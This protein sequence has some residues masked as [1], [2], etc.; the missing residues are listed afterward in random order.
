MTV[1]AEHSTV[2]EVVRHDANR[3]TIYRR[4]ADTRVAFLTNVYILG[5]ADYSRLLAA[6]P[7]VDLIILA[8]TRNACT[9]DVKE[10]AME[11]GVAI[12]N[13]PSLMRALRQRNEED[14]LEFGYSPTDRF[15]NRPNQWRWP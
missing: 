2:Q 12:H 7:D 15:G 5:E 1:V 6:H 4:K 9:M 13:F 8:S 3:Y 14:F 11:D 10:A